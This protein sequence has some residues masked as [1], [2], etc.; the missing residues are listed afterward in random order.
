MSF[1]PIRPGDIIA[2]KYRADRVLGQGGMGIVIAATHL[3]LEV[4]VAIKFVLPEWL[5]NQDA[6]ARFL[7]EGRAAAKIKSEHVARVLDVGKLDNGSPFLVMEYL[8]GMDLAA[9]IR[10]GWLAVHEAVGY[11]LQT[12]EALAEAHAAGIIHRDIKPANLFIT[13]RADKSA[14]VKVLDFGISKVKS[15]K[16]TAL[17]QAQGTILGSLL[18]MSPEQLRSSKDVDHRADVWALGVTLYEL[19]TGLLPFNAEEFPELVVQIVMAPPA[20]LRTR[21]ADIPEALERVVM[22]CLEKD[23]QRRISNVAELAQRLV[24]FALLSDRVSADRASRVL[25]VVGTPWAP[26]GVAPT[27]AATVVASVSPQARSSSGGPGVPHTQAWNTAPAFG[28]TEGRVAHPPPAPPLRARKSHATYLLLGAGAAALAGIGLIVAASSSSRTVV[29]TGTVSAHGAAAPVDAGAAFTVMKVP[30]LSPPAPMEA[31][32]QAAPARPAA[33]A[34]VRP[35]GPAVPPRPI[36][37]PPPPAPPRV[38]PTPKPTPT[39]EPP[40]I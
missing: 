13:R 38:A 2:G 27:V 4:P 21:R 3:E 26:S 23:R 14:C 19:L 11:I 35:P 6:V 33:P 12:C 8:E 7:R 28:A 31:G 10:G 32:T 22:D 16:S 9:R 18:Y 24:P 20:P 40:P 37:P 25:D 36:V 39:Y 34:A 15:T 17:T 5:E 1:S 30:E 29:P